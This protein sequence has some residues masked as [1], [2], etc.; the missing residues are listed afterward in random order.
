MT[1]YCK[2]CGKTITVRP[3]RNIFCDNTCSNAHKRGGIFFDNTFMQELISLREEGW[4]L[5]ELAEYFSVNISS[6]GKLLNGQIEY[7]EKI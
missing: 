6:I 2:A 4:K 5:K 1:K 7:G 3:D